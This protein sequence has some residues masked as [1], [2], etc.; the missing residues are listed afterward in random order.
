MKSLIKLKR[1][2]TPSLLIFVFLSIFAINILEQVQGYNNAEAK[3]YPFTP[4]PGIVILQEPHT[5]PDLEGWKYLGQYEADILRVKKGRE[6][7]IK[8]YQKDNIKLLIA[9]INNKPWAHWKFNTKT[10]ETF[11]LYGD[12]DGDGNFE[13]YREQGVATLKIDEKC[14]VD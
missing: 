1:P 11:D 14:Y 6:S 3:E 12:Y 7:L 8:G 2:I 4:N 9:Y 5:L 10:K 13:Q